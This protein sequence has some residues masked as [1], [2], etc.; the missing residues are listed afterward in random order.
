MMRVL[1]LNSPWINTEGEYCVKAG[2]RW[3]AVRRKDRSLQYFP[4]PYFMA[5]TKAFLLK[6]GFEAHI[7][8]AVAEEWSKEECLQ[9]VEAL[10]PDLLVIEAFTPS[11]AVDLEFARA[12]KERTGCL[13]AFCGAHPTALP[14]GML[15]HEHIDFVLMREYDFPLRD[16]C[17][18]LAS[19]HRDFAAVGGLAFRDDE[20]QY[21]LTAPR[22]DKFDYDEMPLP[23]YDELPMLK[24]T[25]PLSKFYPTAR[26]VTSR[27][28]P[29]NCSFCIEPLVAGRNYRQRSIPKVMEEIRGLQER[30]GV[31]E[32][33]F[34]DAIL[35]IPRTKKI[36]HG[37]IE[38]GVDV[39]WTAWVDWRIG[40]DDLKLLRDSGCVGIKFGVE[41]SSELIRTNVGK[42]KLVKL[43]QIR[44]AVGNCKRLG[45]LAHGSFLVGGPGETRETL[46]QTI[47]LC[48]DL[49][50]DS[51]QWS[52]AT[53]LPGTPFYQQAKDEGWLVTDDWSQY[54]PL[55]SCVLQ[56]EECTPQD[57][58]AGMHQV[59]R[60][61]AKQMLTDPRKMA[62]YLWKTFRLMGPRTFVRDC[63]QKARFVAS[64]MGARG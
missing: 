28:C 36:A 50:L 1:L 5:S 45:V 37:L 20:G 11:I 4:F 57:I 29:H 39:A 59:R 63:L 3:A 40:L 14:E 55:S 47:D 30:F 51:S 60:R 17:Q 25:E 31:R 19:G 27:G 32:I 38:H 12:A 44:E 10:A 9:Q 34:D 58:V 6:A 53:P 15:E 48:F 52:I 64:N 16:L 33:Y 43:E 42:G 2:T 24:Y 41:S 7:Y 49:D 13:N 35:T 54:D 26:V 61:K 22:N 46:Q 21:Q 62:T 18:R 23:L 56:Y 8:D